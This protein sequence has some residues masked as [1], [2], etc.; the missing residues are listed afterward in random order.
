[1]SEKLH[2]YEQYDEFVRPRVRDRVRRTLSSKRI[3]GKQVGKNA[4]RFGK[5]KKNLEGD[6][7]RVDGCQY[8]IT[9]RDEVYDFETGRRIDDPDRIA[10]VL[11]VDD[12]F[13]RQQQDEA[14]Y[15]EWEY[16][17]GLDEI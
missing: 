12:D 16:L 13:V 11:G 6:V 3:P 10:R 7:C 4:D 1:M 14:G 5:H 15:D 9:E 8:L 17:L 2:K